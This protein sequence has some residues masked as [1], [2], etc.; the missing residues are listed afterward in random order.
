MPEGAGEFLLYLEPACPMAVVMVVVKDD[1]S[2]R[3]MQVVLAGEYSRPV[4]VEPVMAGDPFEEGGDGAE[5]TAEGS[6]KR[7]GSERSPAS[8]PVA[9]MPAGEAPSPD[10]GAKTEEKAADFSAFAA[11]WMIYFGGSW[12]PAILPLAV[13]LLTI[14]R[15]AVLAQLAALLIAQ[16]VVLALAAW[17]A[18]SVPDGATP[19]LGL[20]MAGVAVEALFHSEMRWWRLPLVTAAGILAGLALGA[21]APFRRLFS[22]PSAASVKEV[23][24][25]VAGT[26]AGFVVVALVAVAVLL[27]TARFAWQRRSLVQPLAAL[28]AGYGL[29]VAVERFL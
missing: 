8:A 26:E 16:S 21:A 29:F 17:G 3:R 24:L 5:K 13:F 15:R 19:A 25:C 14:R 28:L 4:N 23:L 2:S 6:A 27:S 11:G 22:D 18:V 20:V 9:A 10:D 7:G 12:L 1:R